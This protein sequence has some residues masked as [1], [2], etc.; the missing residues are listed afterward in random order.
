MST[1][2]SQDLRCPRCDAHVRP[3]A[4]WCTLCYCDLRP[5]PPPVE[6]QPEPGPEPE[7]VV[8]PRRGKHARPTTPGTAATA[9][10]PESS[11][12]PESPESSAPRLPDDEVELMLAQ[13]AATES[14]IP[15]GRFA[16]HLDS[17]GRKVGLMIGGSVAAAVLVFL[18]MA[19]VGVML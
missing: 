2:T 14:G 11:A 18:L 9:A 10:T 3:G 7:P 8:V 13:L 4:D 19:V 15:L 17:P 12:S 5:A 16:R 1:S 6:L